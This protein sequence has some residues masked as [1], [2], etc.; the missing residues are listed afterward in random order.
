MC[1]LS[2]LCLANAFLHTEQRKTY[3]PQSIGTTLP[4]SFFYF[5]IKSA[6]LF[7]FKN[8]HNLHVPTR[9]STNR[10]NC[11][12]TGYFKTFSLYFK[13][14]NKSYRHC[15]FMA[16]FSHWDAFF[17]NAKLLVLY[18]NGLFASAL[19]SHRCLQ[20]KYVYTAYNTFYLF[21]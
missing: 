2:S 18:W 15:Q 14:I 21:S 16:S 17:P 3:L 9:L 13:L 10:K 11:Q 19:A 6:C 12:I 7:S 1:T 20:Y 5:F 8:D 4:F